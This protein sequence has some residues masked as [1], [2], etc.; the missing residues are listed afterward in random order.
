MRPAPLTRPL[1]AAPPR[2]ADRGAA[3]RTGGVRAA[4]SGPA[5]LAL[6]ALLGGC[7]GPEAAPL[8]PF[9][10][11]FAS[12]TIDAPRLSPDGQ[13]L[14]WIG[15]AQGAPNL[16]VA[17]IED[18]SAA[19]PLTWF[20]GRGV[21]SRDVSGNLLWR[22]T[23]DSRR[24]V[25]PVDPSGG[26]RF[27]LY[28]VEVLGGALV[29]LAEDT[30]AQA[31]LAAL[32]PRRPHLAAMTSDARQP[33][34]PDLFVVDLATGEREVMLE[35]PGFYGFLVDHALSPRLALGPGEGASL[36]LYRSTEDGW[37]PARAIA[38]EDLP[39]FLSSI[40]QGVQE[41]DAAGER[42]FLLD[43]RGRDV[44]ALCALDLATGELS[45]VAQDQRVDV[46]GVLYHPI[47]RTPQ[48]WS[49]TWERTTWKALDEAIGEEL[50][51][52]SAV[53]KGDVTVVSRDDA[54]LRWIVRVVVPHSPTRY[55]LFERAS[56]RL[57]QVLVTTP[58][59]TGLELAHMHPFELR[60]R[61]GL[62]LVSYVA[63][64]P[65]SDPDHDGRPSRP[66]P[67]VM[68]VHGGPDDERI[69]WTYSSLVQWLANRGYAV[70]AVNFRGSAGFGKRFMNAQNLEWGGRMHD[71]LIE[72]LDWAIAQ[73]IVDEDR[74]G[75]M[76]GSYGGYATLVGMTFTPTRF[77][78]GVSLVGPSDLTEFLPHWSVDLMSRKVGD[79]RTEEGRDLLRERSPVFR[80]AEAAAP[81]LIG[82]GANDS[83]VPTDQ[84]WR[85]VDA[86]GDHGKPVAF[87]LYPDEGHGLA[88]LENVRSFWGL[89]EVFLARNLG[90]RAEPLG[91]KLEGSS[92]EVVVGKELLLGP[93]GTQ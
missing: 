41:V 46:D 6:A 17:P 19:G 2:G 86:L 22:W 10:R 79:P 33:G 76:G 11:F 68:L 82:H 69:T 39:A 58:A 20:Q 26:E 40:Y 87:A 30:T 71:D 12:P 57:L 55:M 75:I 43:S 93:D 29:S 52:L 21:T 59:L 85:M 27:D 78:C 38:T 9:D 88:R 51:Y 70:L 65:W 81:I 15:P 49:R 1:G 14:A 31:K 66:L 35:N 47:E 91:D 16:W 37:V 18:L 62:D 72:Q 24:I 73:G 74:V 8:L 42:A 4:S 28:A 50:E 60:T 34:Q 44:A 92:L 5:A 53:L 64:P 32:D 90:G 25:F 89:V 80:A 54:D 13:W 84:A 3:G 48:A 23:H 83:R 7:A 77:A 56:R 45:V 63:L 36:A 67:A 61:D